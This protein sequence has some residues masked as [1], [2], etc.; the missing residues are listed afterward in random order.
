MRTHNYRY[1]IDRI[2]YHLYLPF[3]QFV[4]NLFSKKT[5]SIRFLLRISSCVNTDVMLPKYHWT[6]AL[7]VSC[8]DLVI[9]YPIFFVNFLNSFLSFKSILKYFKDITIIIKRLIIGEARLLFK[10]VSV[11]LKILRVV[12]LY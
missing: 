3:C 8:G 2:S 7:P 9:N 6:S 12:L 11:N 10:R 4:D 5:S 1:I